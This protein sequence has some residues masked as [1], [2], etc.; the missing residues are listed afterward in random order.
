MLCSLA[1]YLRGEQARRALAL[2]TSV[3]S[4]APRVRALAAIA[5]AMPE[6]EGRVIYDTAWKAA[7]RSANVDV[8]GEALTAI[9]ISMA[10]PK[11]DQMDQADWAEMTPWWHSYPPRARGRALQNFPRSKPS[12]ITLALRKIVPLGTVPVCASCAG[13][14]WRLRRAQVYSDAIFMSSSTARLPAAGREQSEFPICA[15][16][17]VYTWESSPCML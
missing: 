3:R 4:I 16:K 8:R 15:A 13:L 1:P 12:P 7:Q 6:N 10:S 14:V 2:A 17:G 11:V 5:R 9:T